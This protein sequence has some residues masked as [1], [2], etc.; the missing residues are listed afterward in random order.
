[1]PDTCP[2]HRRQPVAADSSA[3]RCVRCG[4]IVTIEPSV[5]GLAWQATAKRG[6]VAAREARR[7][8]G[9]IPPSDIQSTP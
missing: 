5:V 2:P 3:W 8:K 1:M 9:A 7:E 4:S 6:G